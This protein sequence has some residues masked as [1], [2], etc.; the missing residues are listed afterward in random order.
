MYNGAAVSDV[1]KSVGAVR[2]APSAELI[3]DKK[4]CE[5]IFACA[6]QRIRSDNFRLH[7]PLTAPKSSRTSARAVFTFLI[8]ARCWE[9]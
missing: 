2:V 3:F 6:V 8:C 7:V 5:V 4:L 1:G 9:I